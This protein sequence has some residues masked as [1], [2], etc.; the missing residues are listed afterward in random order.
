MYDKP[1]T[2]P[3]NYRLGE[4]E[5]DARESAAVKL[6]YEMAR[7]SGVIGGACG[8][9]AMPIQARNGRGEVAMALEAQENTT[10]QLLQVVEMLSH[11]LQPVLSPSP[12][13]DKTRGEGC[14]YGSAIATC[15]EQNTARIRQAAERIAVLVNDLAI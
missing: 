10:H 9:P 12:A 4:P 14:G 1:S 8:S 6:E 5:Q 3:G 2:A 15:V 7:Q 11:K 13:S